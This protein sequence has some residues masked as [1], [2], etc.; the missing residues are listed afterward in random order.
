MSKRIMT[1]LLLFTFTLSVAFLS[2]MHFDSAIKAKTALLVSCVTNQSS[3][4]LAH[5]Q[6]PCKAVAMDNISWTSLLFSKKP[7]QVHFLDLL[8]LLHAKR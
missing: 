1:K 5:H 6:H 3:L 8:E 4:P 2:S 7:A